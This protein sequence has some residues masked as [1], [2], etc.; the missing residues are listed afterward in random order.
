MK[1]LHDRLD[2]LEGKI[3]AIQ[4][5]LVLLREKFAEF[6]GRMA[7]IISAMS[8]LISSAITIGVGLIMRNL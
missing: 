8:A 4:V 6:K 3:D 5:D 1:E 2:R 7:I